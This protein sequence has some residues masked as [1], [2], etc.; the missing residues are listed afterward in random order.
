[1]Q[2]LFLIFGGQCRSR[3]PIYLHDSAIIEENTAWIYSSNP[4]EE[5]GSHVA[6][7][8]DISGDGI[9]DVL[10]GAENGIVRIFFGG[11]S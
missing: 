3:S 1:M 9:D 8:G 6:P 11:G 7:A 4:S 5:F 10:I 2:T